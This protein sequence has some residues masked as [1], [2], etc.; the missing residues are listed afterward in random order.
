M[1]FST[2]G[3]EWN[4]SIFHYH[5]VIANIFAW[6]KLCTQEIG[7]EN[8]ILAGYNFQTMTENSDWEIQLRNLNFE[9]SKNWI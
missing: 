1:K 6:N 3:P 8:I 7:G 2:K 5:Q 4:F 9:K